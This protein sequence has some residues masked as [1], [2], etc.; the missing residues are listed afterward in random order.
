MRNRFKVL[1]VTGVPG[2]GKTTVLQHFSKMAEERG[3]R[4]LTVNF[5]DFMVESAI[6]EGIVKSRDE[7]RK[8]P[9]RKQLELQ[10]LAAARIVERADESLPEGGM[11]VVDTHALVKTPAGYWPGLPEHVLRRLKPDAIVVVEAEPELVVERQGR[12]KGRQRADIGG[13]EG[14]RRMMELARAAAMASAVWYASTVAIVHNRE[15]EPW[16]AAS[17]ILRIVESI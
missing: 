1:V 17:E 11:L 9:L 16:A 13:V 3:V 12:D 14:V 8:L 7:L 4:V 2:V 15:G 6:K 5:G 10:A